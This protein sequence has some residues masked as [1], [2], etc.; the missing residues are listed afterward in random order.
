MQ[1]PLSVPDVLQEEMKLF[2]FGYITVILTTAVVLGED[3]ETCM[4]F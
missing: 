4:I 2:V 3:F 1:I